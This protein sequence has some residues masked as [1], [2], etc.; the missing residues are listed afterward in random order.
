[1][2]IGQRLLKEFL[3]NSKVIPDFIDPKLT[4][5]KNAFFVAQELFYSLKPLF[6]D[7]ILPS[8]RI[9]ECFLDFT[10]VLEKMI[11]EDPYVTIDYLKMIKNILTYYEGISLS[12]EGFEVA[13]NIKNMRSI[14]NNI[15]L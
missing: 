12:E 13:E 1:M 5:N 8:N 4:S 9:D 2:E 10:D 11:N 3:D 15:I 14:L 7:Y 6:K